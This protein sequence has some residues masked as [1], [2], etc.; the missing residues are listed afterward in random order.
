MPPAPSC[1]SGRNPRPTSP[2]FPRRRITLPRRRGEAGCVN[3]ELTIGDRRPEVG[4]ALTGLGGTQERAR[5]WLVAEIE[6][7]A[8]AKRRAG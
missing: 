6:R 4:G 8:E 2:P 7:I 1:W 5:E 3:R